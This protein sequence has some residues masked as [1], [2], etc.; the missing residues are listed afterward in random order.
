[1]PILVALPC[2]LK[3]TASYVYP[4]NFLGFEHP[5]QNNVFYLDINN[6]LIVYYSF[7]GKVTHAW[8]CSTILVLNVATFGNC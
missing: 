1:M 2:E 3:Y 4:T 5:M 7:M 6:A 8:V